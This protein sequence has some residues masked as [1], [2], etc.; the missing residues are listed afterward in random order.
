MMLLE[1]ELE[2]KRRAQEQKHEERMQNKFFHFIQ[3]FMMSNHTFQA[4][5]SSGPSCTPSH[6]LFPHQSV[7]PHPSIPPYHFSNHSYTDCDDEN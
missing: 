5:L 1:A 3:Q 4:N 6:P 2:E 7:S